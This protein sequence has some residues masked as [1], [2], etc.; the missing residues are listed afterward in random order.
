MKTL[1]NKT[2]HKMEEAVYEAIRKTI[3]RFRKNPLYAFT[4]CDL[5]S[6]LHA[7][8]I[9]GS[10][11]TFYQ[12]GDQNISLVHLEYPTNFRFQKSQL[13]NG[14]T[15]LSRDNYQS[16][17]TYIT[18]RGRRGNFDLS[19]L[20]PAFIKNVNEYL[21]K[22]RED[23]NNE[24][25][26]LP[27]HIVNK[28]IEAAKERLISKHYKFV[29]NDNNQN[30]F[31]SEI[32]FAIEFKYFHV[33]NAR[34]IN[35]IDEVIRDNEKLRLAHIHSGGFIK[36]INLVF[37]STEALDRKDNQPQIINRLKDFIISGGYVRENRKHD[38]SEGVLTIFIESYYNEAV[39][40]TTKPIAFS[41]VPEQW[42][43]TL[44]S[45]IGTLYHL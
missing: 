25:R 21:K 32:M 17:Q 42:M 31:E 11:N 15:D 16:H 22:D 36:P 40:K 29:E 3:N 18:G 12:K 20:N 38:L 39:K 43:K 41:P 8:L 5:H 10:S 1:P 19:V 33:F 27:Y 35:M 2:A 28:N 4:E 6:Y 34:N 7:D 26:N 9:A 44:C 13:L 30:P 24:I 45:K 23:G 14:Y 37:C